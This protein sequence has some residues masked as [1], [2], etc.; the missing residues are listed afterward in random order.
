MKS[1]IGYARCG[2]R[3]RRYITGWCSIILAFFSVSYL[4]AFASSGPFSFHFHFSYA[5][6][7]H[8]FLSVVRLWCAFPFFDIDRIRLFDVDTKE[9]NK[10][11]VTRFIIHMSRTVRARRWT[12]WL[13]SISRPERNEYFVFQRCFIG[14]QHKTNKNEDVQIKLRI[15]YVERCVHQ[16]Y[17]CYAHVQF[18]YDVIFIYFWCYCKRQWNEQKNWPLQIRTR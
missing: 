2:R 17:Y 16:Q 13:L 7:D 8:H 4:A 10:F 14:I 12:K 5:L 18:R 1:W 6:S 11:C 3:Y 9:T 15:V